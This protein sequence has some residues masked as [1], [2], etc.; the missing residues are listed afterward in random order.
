M[1]STREKQLEIS[2]SRRR[3]SPPR[4][5]SSR[6]EATLPARHADGAL[7]P[8]KKERGERGDEEGPAGGAANH[9]PAQGSAPKPASAEQ[10]TR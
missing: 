7:S 10:D 6:T 1:L 2:P 4:A 8:A 9:G 5:A 3:T